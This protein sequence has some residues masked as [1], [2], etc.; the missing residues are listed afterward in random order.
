MKE[1]FAMKE[2]YLLCKVSEKYGRELLNEVFVGKSDKPYAQMTQILLT[3]CGFE[4]IHQI[5]S[6][7]IK[8]KRKLFDILRKRTYVMGAQIARFLHLPLREALNI[9]C[10]R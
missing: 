1:V 7:D 3:E 6:L 4:D 2:E 10:F 9:D 8:E 5:L